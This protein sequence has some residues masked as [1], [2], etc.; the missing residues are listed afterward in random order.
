M[1]TAVDGGTMNAARS[2]ALQGRPIF[3][4]TPPIEGELFSG[5]AALLQ[6]QKARPLDVSNIIEQLSAAVVST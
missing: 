1:Q 3:C 5:N 6:E 4:L 2:A